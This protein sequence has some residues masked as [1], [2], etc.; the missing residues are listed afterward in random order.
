[1]GL[2]RCS[3]CLHAVKHALRRDVCC[4]RETRL[5]PVA[6][7]SLLMARFPVLH[8]STH[9]IYHIASTPTQPTRSQ[10]PS[11]PSPPSPTTLSHLT[12]LPSLSLPHHIPPHHPPPPRSSAG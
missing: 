10:T 1:M 8:P 12:S 5:L 7:F 2:C 4:P 6:R 9:C 3:S 11:R